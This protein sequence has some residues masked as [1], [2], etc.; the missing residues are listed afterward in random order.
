[1]NVLNV[2]RYRKNFVLLAGLLL[3][4]ATGC[5]NTPELDAAD[6]SES[7]ETTAVSNVVAETLVEVEPMTELIYD[8]DNFDPIQPTRSTDYFKRDAVKGVYVSGHVAGMASSMDALIELA[9]TTEINAFVID[10]KDDDGHITFDMDVEEV[11]EIKS[12]YNYIKDIDGLMDKLYAHDIY[13]I[14]R[15]VAFK[16]PYLAKNK[17]AYAIKNQDGSLW[18]YKKVPWLNPYNRE[19]WDY[20]IEVA[21]GAAK[22]G[23]KEIQ[24]DYIRFEATSSLKNASFGGLEGELTRQEIIL[25]FVKHATEELRP[26][27]VEVSADVFGTVITSEIDAKNIGQDYVAMVNELDVIC[28]MIYPSHYGYGF[29]GTPAGQHSDLYPYRIIKGSMD[30]SAEAIATLPEDAPRAVVRPWLQAFTAS[31]LGKGNYKVYDKA[32]IR[33]QIQ[34]TYDAGLEEWILWH[35]G[36]KYKA[37]YLMPEENETP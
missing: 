6:L 1:M 26:Y 10:V 22:A 29:Y 25:E 31:Y 11:D 12:E 23:F 32:A 33:E 4:T 28:P 18:Y 5:Q 19:C 13:P 27:G 15:I 37:S 2:G 24:F 20:I 3:L 8:F 34:A 16:D 7:V 35:A 9:D 30:D 36:V 21:K 17:Q 14:A